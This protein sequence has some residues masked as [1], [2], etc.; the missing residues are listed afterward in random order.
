M[1]RDLDVLVVGGGAIGICSAYFLAEQGLQVTIVEQKEVA[2]GC[3]GANAGLIVPSHSI[4]LA[5]PGVLC[6]GLKW[7]LKPESPF[8]IKLRFSPILFNWLRRFRKASKYQQM[9]LGLHTLRDLNYS[10]LELFDHII[11]SE[12]LSCDYRK[13]GWLL[14]YRTDKG[15]NK[16]LDEARLLEDH[17]IDVKILSADD[18]LKMEPMLRDEI[19]GGIFFP[20]DAHLDPERFVLALT[21]LLQERGVNIHRQTKVLALEISNGHIKIAR[22][23]K[24]DFKPKQVVLAAGAWSPEL[25]QN[26]SHELLVQPAKGYSI[27]VKKPDSYPSLPLYLGEAKVAVTPLEDIL[28]FAGTMELSGMD[29]SI[30]R[31][32]VDAIMHAARDYL[33]ELEVL[34]IIDT[35]YGFRPCTP[36]GLPL[37]E[38]FPGYDNLI[39]ATGHCM[40]GISLAPITGKLVSQ[41]VRGQTPDMDLSSF[42]VDRFR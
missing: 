17:D 1:S 11:S 38:R 10:S 34:E 25:V 4:P 31:R 2:S 18:T 35:R 39:V 14:A 28:R 8:Y 23:T 27:S 15:L 36:D 21:E 3:S 5:S 13:D 22:T 41:L 42:R 37:I 7:M 30:N 40:L 32:R 29:F 24:E 9:L 33:R 6:Q 26:L 12:S 19:T 16:A 20:D